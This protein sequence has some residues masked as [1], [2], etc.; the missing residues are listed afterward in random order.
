MEKHCILAHITGDSW[1]TSV[2]RWSISSSLHV[3]NLCCTSGPDNTLRRGSPAKC[4]LSLSNKNS[5]G[6]SPAWS[7]WLFVMK[8]FLG[9]SLW[10]G[11]AK[12]GCLEKKYLWGNIQL[13]KVDYDW[14]FHTDGF[15]TQ[16]QNWTITAN[17]GRSGRNF[18]NRVSPCK[19][20]GHQLQHL[21][22]AKV[23]LRETQLRRSLAGHEGRLKPVSNGIVN[24][25]LFIFSF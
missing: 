12:W 3:F 9:N 24:K 5:K 7:K 15:K 13:I 14:G 18:T 1:L 21:P 11:N 16:G 8:T 6:S 23:F 25:W 22:K 2:Y 17:R 19:P 20:W 4:L 10:A